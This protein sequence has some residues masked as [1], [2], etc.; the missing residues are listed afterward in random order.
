VTAMAEWCSE[1]LRLSRL[2]SPCAGWLQLDRTRGPPHHHSCTISFG[3]SVIRPAV[4]CGVLREARARFVECDFREGV[5]T[6]LR[7]PTCGQLC[8]SALTRR[9]GV[10]GW[11]LWRAWHRAND[12]VMGQRVVRRGCLWFTSCGHGSLVVVAQTSPDQLLHMYTL[13]PILFGGM[14]VNGQHLHD[15]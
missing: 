1:E 4:C 12:T 14:T 10:L 9:L 3:P 15:R 11:V 7:P 8:S 5:T 6:Q 2:Y 13:H